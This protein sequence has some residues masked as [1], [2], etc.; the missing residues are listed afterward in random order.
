MRFIDDLCYMSCHFCKR[1]LELPVT[2]E[3]S[4]DSDVKILES[5]RLVMRK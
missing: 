2:I 3:K 4:K 5:A 1:E